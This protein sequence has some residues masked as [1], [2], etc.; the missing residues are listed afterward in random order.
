MLGSTTQPLQTTTKA[1]SAKSWTG[2]G[3]AFPKTA[4]TPISTTAVAITIPTT[5]RRVRRLMGMTACL[6]SRRASPDMRKMTVVR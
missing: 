6:K 3:A 5:T 1:A 2:A 4:W